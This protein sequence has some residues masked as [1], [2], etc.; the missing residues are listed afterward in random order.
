MQTGYLQGGDGCFPNKQ[1]KSTSH[2]G[3]LDQRKLLKYEYYVYCKDNK[4]GLI[5][6]ILYIKINIYQYT[7]KQGHF[8]TP[9][10]NTFY[11]A[12][13]SFMKIAL[14]KFKN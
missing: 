3:L 7:K 6:H 11:S 10:K 5:F 9:L 14:R 1:K 2:D 4:F 13:L 8:T 12:I